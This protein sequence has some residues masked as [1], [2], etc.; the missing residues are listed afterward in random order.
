M[1]AIIATIEKVTLEARALGRDGEP[2]GNPIE[3]TILQPADLDRPFEAVLTAPMVEGEQ[4]LVFVA[5][6]A[7]AA[8]DPRRCR[9]DD[10]PV[11]DDLPADNPVK[12]KR[13]LPVVPSGWIDS[14]VDE[15]GRLVPLDPKTGEPVG[16]IG[17]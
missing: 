6:D 15:T 5:D 14:T 3:V 9:P 11:R 8:D 16:S 10:V 7:V 1:I 13:A 17:P 12:G 4:Q 2:E